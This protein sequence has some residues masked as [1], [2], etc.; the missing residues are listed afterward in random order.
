MPEHTSK[1]LA[2]AKEWWREAVV[3]EIY[4]RS[5][6]DGN[7]DGIGDIAGIRSRLG[8]L[9]ELGIDAIW[10]TPWYLSPQS[11]GGY[12]VTD[13]RQIDPLFGTVAE[14]EALIAEA[15]EHGIRVIPDIVP[16]HTSSEHEWF[17]AA[18]AAGAGAPERDLYVF[19]PG[20]GRDGNLPPNNW[21]SSFGGAAWTRIVEPD[22]EPGEWYLHL[23]AASQPDLDWAHPQVRSEYESILNFWFERGVDGFR[24]DV[25]RGL[26]RDPLLPDLPEGSIPDGEHPYYDREGGHLIYRDWRKVADSYPGDRTF[27]GEL[28]CPPHRIARY[29][30]P[31]EL[32]TA[33]NFDFLW[34]AWDA[35]ALRDVISQTIAELGAVGAPA[36][37]VLSNHDFFRHP[38]RYGRPP[39]QWDGSPGF[40]GFGELDLAL[41]VRRARAA[42][43]LLLSLPGG[44]YVYQGEELGLPEVEDLP[45]HALQD[46]TWW[47]S[48]H[49]RKGRDGARV[50]LPW[51]GKESPFGFSPDGVK[52]WLP[53]PPAWAS[54]SA[55]A[56]AG[57]PTSMLVLYRKALQIRR[58]LLP[59]HEEDFRWLDLAPDTLAFARGEGFVCAVNISALPVTLPPH[60]RILLSSE[61]LSDDGLLAPDQAVWLET[62]V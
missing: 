54:L 14:A 58:E 24:I 42:A 4:I 19:R 31:G 49:A 35:T 15:H 51:S 5:F 8:Y 59:P 33:F 26:D 17:K 7:G 23:H 38:N 20:R 9:R 57:D 32:H 22:G 46:P 48:G 10:I 2:S 28:W 56:Q 47:Q 52:P 11:D 50:P 45:A 43:L 12:D 53:Q 36:T 55:D 44:A 62:H 18:V 21:K 13:Y 1:S 60:R 41:G 25:A 30:R 27:V 29:L 61:P 6:C 40:S 39:Q 37:W 34:A 3:Y 16:K